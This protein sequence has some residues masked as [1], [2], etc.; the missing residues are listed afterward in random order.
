MFGK[1]N[2]L[3]VIL[4]E[5]V[6]LC[7]FQRYLLGM[8]VAV[9]LNWQDFYS[10]VVSLDVLNMKNKYMYNLVGVEYLSALGALFPGKA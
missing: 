8:I 9:S 5:L 2:Y 1:P 3:Q 10:L 6:Y 7:P 4:S